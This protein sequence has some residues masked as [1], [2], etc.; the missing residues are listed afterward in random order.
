MNELSKLLCEKCKMQAIDFESPE[1]FIKLF[2]LITTIENFDIRT[3][4]FF[5][6]YIPSYRQITTLKTDVDEYSSENP[7]PIKAFLTCV[8]KCVS[9]DKDTADYIRETEWE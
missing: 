7:D 9:N 2:K 1:N 5:I 3:G 8:F 4:N 6:P